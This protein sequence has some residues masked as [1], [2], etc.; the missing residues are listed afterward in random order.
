MVDEIRDEVQ[1]I[2]SGIVT[3]TCELSKRI[4]EASRRRKRRAKKRYTR[5]NRRSGL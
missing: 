3:T 2:G 4:E 5:G 1:E